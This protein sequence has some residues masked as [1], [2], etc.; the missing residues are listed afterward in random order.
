[1]SPDYQRLRSI[2]DRIY[3][4]FNDVVDNHSGARGIAGEV[5]NIVED[6]EMNKKPR[7]IDDRVKR[8]IESLKQLRHGDSG[9]M[10]VGDIDELIDQYEDL[11]REIRSLD[12]Y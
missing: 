8:T 3:N 9:T 10:D 12:N 6:F 2:A 11:R 4:R 7:S 5:R 1:M